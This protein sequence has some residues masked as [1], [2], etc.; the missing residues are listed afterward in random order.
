MLGTV[1]DGEFIPSLY[2]KVVQK[3]WNMIPVY[4]PIAALDA[5]QV[6][7]NHIH[8]VVRIMENASN[9]RKEGVVRVA[10]IGGV[11][12]DS[13]G[14]VVQN[15]KSIS[16]R[17]VNRIRRTKGKPLWQRGFRDR[18][19]RNERELNLIRLYI[20]LNPEM[21]ETGLDLKESVTP[22]QIGQILEKYERMKA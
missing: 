14:A 18:I 1:R 8:G 3:L 6:M 9:I 22:E 11:K 20:E 21:W 19:I 13:L 5:F 2:G 12:S 10:T 15:F 7:P 16:T 17:R 4:F